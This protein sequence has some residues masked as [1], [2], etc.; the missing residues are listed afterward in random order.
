MRRVSV[1]IPT[2]GEK[3]LKLTIECLKSIERWAH[4][5][6][7]EVIVVDDGSQIR[8]FG[9]ILGRAL[10]ETRYFDKRFLCKEGNTGFSRTC[11]VGIEEA[12]KET[13]II[14]LNNDTIAENDF[15]TLMRDFAH[16]RDEIGI[17]GP[18]LI[19]PE[20]MG[21]QSA[22]SFLPLR[23]YW[24]DHVGRFKSIGHP[25]YCENYK[26]GIVTG[27]CMYIKREVLKDVEWPVDYQMCFEDVDFCLEAQEKGWEVWFQHKPLLTH[28]ENITKNSSKKWM[29]ES[30]IKFWKK[31]DIEKNDGKPKGKLKIVKR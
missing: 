5:S 6:L 7:A 26:A 13:D 30:M 22:G 8:D 11:N 1:I 31:W 29:Q 10:P 15:I 28:F 25:D 23:S 16:S 18:K 14:L 2:Y 12:V 20:G 17:I 19:Y 21:I 24:F 4:D 27:A 3:G 9:L